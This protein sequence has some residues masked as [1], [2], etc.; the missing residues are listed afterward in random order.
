MINGVVI[1]GAGKGERLGSSVP[2]CLLKVENVPLI[3]MAAFPFEKADKVKEIVLVLPKECE[4]EIRHQAK[5]LGFRKI[6]AIV[7]GGELRQDSV[8]SG[9]N[10]LSD[11]VDRVMI[12]DGARCLV[13][14]EIIE[15]IIRAMKDE[16]AVL[17]AIEVGDTIHRINRNFAD[18]AP[19]RKELVAAQTPQGFTKKLISQA[20]IKAARER[21][22]VS[23]EVTLVRDVMGVVSFIVSGDRCNVKITHP[24]DLDLYSAQLQKRALQVKEGLR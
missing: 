14:S 15:R 4:E 11:E 22:V 5:E 16:P 1:V 10:A 9:L 23:D 3:L 8:L 17:A 18:R 12:H 7:P 20:F 2:K 19:D 6:R 13:S 24:D 21:L